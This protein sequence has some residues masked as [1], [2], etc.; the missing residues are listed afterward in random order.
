MPSTSAPSNTTVSRLSAAALTSEPSSATGS[1][2]SSIDSIRVSFGDPR[3]QGRRG[4]RG[5]DP[6]DVEEVRLGHAGDVE[7]GRPALGGADEHHAGGAVVVPAYGA[8]DRALDPV[9]VGQVVA[10][11]QAQPGPGPAVRSGEEDDV[12]SRPDVVAR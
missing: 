10:A 11:D 1:S 5:D 3:D 12:A 2:R 4:A 8:L 9:G 6:V 7:S